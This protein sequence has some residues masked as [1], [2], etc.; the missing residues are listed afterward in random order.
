MSV[1]LIESL[2]TTEP[3]AE[4]FSDLSVLQAMLDFE[5]ALARSEAELKIIPPSAA[6]IIARVARAENFDVVSLARETLRAGTPSIPLVKALRKKAQEEDAAAADFV[7]WGA[8]SQDVS[9]TAL[10]LLLKKAAAILSADLKRLEAA[11]D[12]LVIQNKN[13]VMVGRT[14]LQ[15]APPITFGLKAAGWCGAI[16]RGHARLHAAFSDAL[17]LQLG[18]ASGTLAALGNRGDKVRKQVAKRLKLDDPDAPWHT[19]RDRLAAVV[20]ACGVLVGSIGKMARDISLL[21]QAEVGEL[22]EPGGSGRGGSST[23]P[24]K[25]N[26]IAS[27]IALAA[28]YRVPVLV[29]SFLSEMVQEHERAVG[30]LQAEWPTVAGVI[31]STGVAIASMV[32]ATE[33]L[34]VNRKRMRENLEETQGAVYAEKAAL[35]LSRKLGREPAHSLLQQA[36]RPQQLRKGTLSEILAQLPEVQTFFDARALR[37]LDDPED[38]LGLAREFSERLCG[39][40]RTRPP[41]RKK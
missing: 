19:H 28:S 41:A 12:S 36:T 34:T 40:S 4:I 17:I 29:A 38:Y 24:Q 8:T 31:Q 32:E 21:M 5:G 3:L 9:D 18:G 26:P 2:S 39:R 22:S 37:T 16:R 15:P 33:G 1:R 7:H 13:T 23:M 11:L 6:R 20:C 35:L 27:V 25:R 30:G 10:V 14:L